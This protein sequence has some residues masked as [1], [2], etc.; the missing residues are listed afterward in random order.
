[1]NPNDPRDNAPTRLPSVVL[2]KV[3]KRAHVETH[4]VY[5]PDDRREPNALR[6]EC[7]ALFRELRFD[8]AIKRAQRDSDWERDPMARLHV[9]LGYAYQRRYDE[10]REEFQR[11]ADLSD[12]GGFKSTCIAN[13][14]TVW[15]EVGDFERALECYDDALRLHPTREFALLGRVF[16]ACQRCDAEAVLSAVRLLRERRPDWRESPSI[17]EQILK[18]RSYRF[19]RDSPGLFERVFEVPLQVLIEERICTVP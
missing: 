18:D 11:A 7:A 19:L 10:A 5:T 13:I 15:F 2:Q 17:I 12:R 14:G 1:M 9:G 8:E 3:L 6:D 16:V 4:D